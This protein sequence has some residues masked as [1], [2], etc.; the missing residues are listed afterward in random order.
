MN[1]AIRGI[2]G[3]IAR[4]DSFHND[5]HP[6]LKADYILANP[7]FNV[8]DWGGERLVEDKRWRYG[9]PRLTAQWRRQQAEA[10]RLDSAIEKS[11][12]LLDFGTGRTDHAQ[13]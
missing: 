3:Q 1:L 8:S 9:V 11:L 4:S 10:K 7:P 6:D 12:A 5:R 2:A 13:G